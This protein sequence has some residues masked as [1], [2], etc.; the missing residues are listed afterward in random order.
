ML[1]EGACG[2]F[3]EP[4]GIAAAGAGES[5]IG[6]LAFGLLAPWVLLPCCFVIP[7]I[8]APCIFVAPCAEPPGAGIACSFVPFC[9]DMLPMPIR[10][11]AR[12]A[13]GEPG[14]VRPGKS[15]GTRA[16]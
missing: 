13:A 8:P 16:T 15:F 7:G 6:A 12:A 4:P 10:C 14:T 2:F 11:V 1:L 9:I 3:V 5:R